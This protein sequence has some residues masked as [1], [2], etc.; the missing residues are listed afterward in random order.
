[1][2][3][4]EELVFY[5]PHHPSYPPDLSPSDFLEFLGL[6]LSSKETGCRRMRSHITYFEKK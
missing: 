4:T 1:M 2:A 6:K 3:K 5:L